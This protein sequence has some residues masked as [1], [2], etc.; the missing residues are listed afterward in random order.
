MYWGGQEK[1]GVSILVCLQEKHVNYE[2]L[3]FCVQSG[4]NVVSREILK[5]MEEK[6]KP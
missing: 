2:T 5:T 6:I 1:L 4:L 3:D